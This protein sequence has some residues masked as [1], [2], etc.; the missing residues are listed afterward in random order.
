MNKYTLMTLLLAFASTIGFAQE[1]EKTAFQSSTFSSDRGTYTRSGAT[2]GRGLQL[3]MGVGYE[4]MDDDNDAFKTDQAT[5]FAAQLRLGLSDKVELDF[6]I[7]NRELIIRNWA[8]GKDKYNYWSPLQIGIRAQIIDAKCKDGNFKTQG[9]LYLGMGINTTQRNHLDDDDMIRDWVL[10]ER[11]SFV[12]PEFALLMSHDIKSRFVLGY[13]FGVK[14]TDNG[15]RPDAFYS[16]RALMHLSKKMD[17]YAEHYNFMRKKVEP[18][19]GLNFGVRY[20]ITKGI[21]L[22]I[23]GGTGLNENSSVGF[24]GIGFTFNLADNK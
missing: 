23:N 14:W 7:A 2:F 15:K 10:V 21:M 5:P 3:E 24:A 18:N 4:W 6:A 17:F 22:D 16:I 19:L 1:V 9:S 20:A 13:N 8:D 11:P 12:A